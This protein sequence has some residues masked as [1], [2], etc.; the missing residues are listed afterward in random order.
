MSVSSFIH[1]TAFPGDSCTF[2]QH[3]SRGGQTPIDNYFVLAF[4][5]ITA[6]QCGCDRPAKPRESAANLTQFVE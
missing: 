2:C 5:D 1:S 3:R 4:N 6:G